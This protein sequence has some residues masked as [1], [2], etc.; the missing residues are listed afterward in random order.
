MLAESNGPLGSVQRAADAIR[1]S[2]SKDAE[3]NA[4]RNVRLALLSLPRDS[5]NVP[6]VPEVRFRLRS[7]PHDFPTLREQFSLIFPGLT[8]ILCVQ[9]Q[10]DIKEVIEIL[11][12]KSDASDLVLTGLVLMR[13]LAQRVENQKKIASA[14]GVSLVLHAL[15]THDSNPTLQV[16][17]TKL[18]SYLSSLI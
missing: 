17:L 3:P 1:D 4:L 13:Y 15:Q 7:N 9:Q 8:C 5:S 11:R 16:L 2:T 6:D 18:F 14:R 10:R 12:Q